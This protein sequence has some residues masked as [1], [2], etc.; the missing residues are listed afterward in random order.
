MIAPNVTAS[1]RMIGPM[2]RHVRRKLCV[3]RKV[4][5]PRAATQTL[6]INSDS[7]RVT[8]AVAVSPINAQGGPGD[9]SVGFVRAQVS[10]GRREAALL[11]PQEGIARTPKGDA[12]ALVVGADGKVEVRPVA[13]S[14]AVG[15]RWLV[16][17][18]LSAGDR[19]IVEGLQKVQPGMPAHAVE[20]AA[21]AAAGHGAPGG[22]PAKD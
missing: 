18:G 10:V 21:P 12:T 1:T 5:Q 15:D 7:G 3:L 17:S 13:V 14:R 4:V 16:E 22:L 6:Q 11:V 20:A 8:R 2:R 9:G 19:V